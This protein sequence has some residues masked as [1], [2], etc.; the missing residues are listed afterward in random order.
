VPLEEYI[1]R[2]VPDSPTTTNLDNSGDQHTE[3]H[4]LAAAGVRAVQ[5]IP[6][7][8]VIIRYVPEDATA[9]KIDN[10]GAQHTEIQV[11]LS[12]ADLVVHVLTHA[13][14]DA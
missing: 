5:L 8:E 9:T 6:S 10:S 4:A 7:G 2:Y 14:A 13:S 3:R 12:S 11:L 1:T